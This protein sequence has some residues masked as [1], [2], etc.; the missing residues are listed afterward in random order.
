M[1]FLLSLI[2]YF[3]IFSHAFVFAAQES[4]LL[5]DESRRKESEKLLELG[6]KLAKFYELP[7]NADIKDIT[8]ELLQSSLVKE[9]RK[10]SIRDFERRI[11]VFSYPSDGLQ[12]KGVV[13]FVPQPQDNPL[14]VFLRGGNRI[15]GILNPASDFMCASKYTVISTMYRGGV[16]EG[17]DEF[18]GKDV[19]DVNNLIAFIPHLE[20]RLN[21]AFQNEKMF[22]IGGSRG[23]MQMFLALARF[24]ELQNRFAKVV[25]LSGM[26]DMR[27]CLATRPDMEEMFIQEFGFT[28]DENEEEWINTRDP[29]LAADQIHSDVPI[30]IIQGTKDNRVGL[31]EGYHMVSKLQ[32]NGK[33]VTYWEFEGSQHCLSDL[34][35]RVKIILN[36]L[37]E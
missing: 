16:S 1:C 26:L 17:D 15:F 18:G 6:E 13:S 20:Q 2:I 14:L 28:K 19:N 7:P 24:P 22:M 31:E 37:E 3:A 27:E 29:L 4:P 11:C 32:A 23:G 36:W 34:D 30:L 12:V 9:A 21:L 33:N 35:E 8:E 5:D 25:S 10:Q